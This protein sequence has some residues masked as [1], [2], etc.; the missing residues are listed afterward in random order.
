MKREQKNRK[1]A[2]RLS[3]ETIRNLSA[4]QLGGVAGGSV[5]ACTNNGCGSGFTN[6]PTACRPCFE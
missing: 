5:D 6:L 1:M 2:L 4:S 3:T